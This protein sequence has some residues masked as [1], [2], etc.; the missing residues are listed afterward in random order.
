[1][2]NERCLDCDPKTQK[3]FVNTC[4]EKN[5]NMMWTFGTVNRTALENYDKEGAET[6]N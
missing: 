1:M 6:K 3:L 4:D 2:H 5:V